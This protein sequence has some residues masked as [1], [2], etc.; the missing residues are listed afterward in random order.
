MGKV[1]VEIDY[2]FCL[3]SLQPIVGDRLKENFEI[4]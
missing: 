1:D 2:L 4:K 3:N